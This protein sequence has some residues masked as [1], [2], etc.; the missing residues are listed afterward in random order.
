MEEPSSG[1]GI[2]NNA[3]DLSVIVGYFLM[4]IGVGVWVSPSVCFYVIKT[5]GKNVTIKYEQNTHNIPV[6]CSPC[7]VPTVGRWGDISWRDAPWLG[8]R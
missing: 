2:I 4:V 8:G 5:L 6:S 7:F 3:A 1:K